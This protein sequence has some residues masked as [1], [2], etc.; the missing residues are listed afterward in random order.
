MTLRPLLFAFALVL[1]GLGQTGTGLAVLPDEMLDDPKLE[2]RA[3]EISK[4]VRCLVCQNQSIDDSNAELARDLRI[5]VRER[6][7]AGDSNEEVKGFL[8]D[9]YG[10]YVLLKPPVTASTLLLW[11]APVLLLL[12]GFGAIVLW[13]RGRA[14]EAA[15]G[16][17]GEAALS[18]DERAR[19]ERLLSDDENSTRP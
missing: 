9:R 13:Y 1:A 14:R 11:G 3:R 12:A 2:Q 5:L 19:L 16:L 8:V 18:S 6:I 17:A 15:A 10:E 4:D 7:K